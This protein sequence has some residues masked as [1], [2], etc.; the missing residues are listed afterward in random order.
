MVIQNRTFDLL[1]WL[2]PKSE[3]FPR[4]YRYTVIQR[5]MNVAL[6]FQ[7]TLTLAQCSHGRERRKHL[8]TCDAK[9]Q[10]LRQYLRLAHTW[11]WLSD[12]QYHHV[13]EQIAEIGRLLGGWI[14]TA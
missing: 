7:E 12:G 3:S 5:M 1:N 9:L 4:T 2:L 6:D 8:H 13:S 11:K 10:Q 14:K